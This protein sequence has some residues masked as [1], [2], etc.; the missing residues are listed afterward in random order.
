MPAEGGALPETPDP[1]WERLRAGDDGA[2]AL[3]F[4]RH[5]RLIWHVL[6]HLVPVAGDVDDLYQVGALGLV[7]AIRRFEPDRGLRF[8][9]YAV[10]V[11]LGEVRRYLR[12]DQ[13]VHVARSLR[14]RG[15][16][17]QT[18][19]AQLE[20][21][22]GRE[23]TVSELADALGWDV[24]AV[25]ETWESRRPLLS[26]DQPDDSD[27]AALRERVGTDPPEGEWVSRIALSDA[28]GRLA[29]RDRFIVERRFGAGETQSA[30]A[31]RLGLSQVQVSRLERR[32]LTHLRH[33]MEPDNAHHPPDGRTH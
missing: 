18:A 13:P 6:R 31:A 17:L 3:L 27:G 2:A 9:T 23:P 4:E 28:L 32:A 1:L 15:Q 20:Q 7:K 11:I 24:A 12:D 16:A 22:R 8:A 10:P 19:M 14:E 30:V 29:P 21:E 25:V 5:Q 33:L 26:W